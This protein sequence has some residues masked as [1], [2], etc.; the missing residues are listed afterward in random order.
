[1]DDVQLV[2]MLE[3]YPHVMTPKLQELISAKE[4]FSQL[5]SKVGE[6]L[7]EKRGAFFLHQK[8]THR[9]LRT[10]DDLLV[11]SET[12]TGKSCEII[13]F[14]EWA[15]EEMI[16]SRD[17]LSQNVDEKLAH[18]KRCYILARG[19]TQKNEIRNQLA[20]RC[21]RPGKYDTKAVNEANQERTQK[22][23]LT[24]ELKKFYT[25]TTYKTFA[26]KI[27][28]EFP[29]EED[30]E[31]LADAY[32]DCI[33]WVDEAHNLLIDPAVKTTVKEKDQI[34]RTMHRLFHL[35]RR[36][37]R[38][39]ST[40]TPMINGEEEIGSLMN[41]ILP[42]DG[43]I[44]QGFDYIN[45]SDNDLRVFFPD[46]P[47]D[48]RSGVN[49][50]TNAIITKEDIAQ[51]F[52][53]QF[54]PQPYYNFQNAELEDLE[55]YFR[56]RI[57]YVRASNPKVDVKYQGSQLDN[58]III[59]NITYQSLSVL[60]PT[61]M[62]LHQNSG[63]MRAI[64]SGKTDI[65]AEERQASN[66]VFPDG[67][68]GQGISEEEKQILRERKRIKR[69]AKEANGEIT[70]Q[71]ARRKRPEQTSI[72][73]IPLSIGQTEARAFRKYVVVDKDDYYATE[74]L[75]EWLNNLKSIAELSCKYAEIVRLVIEKPGNAFVYGEY[76]TG[77]GT[78]VLA[79]CFEGMG[80]TRYNESSSMFMGV[81]AGKIKPYCAGSDPDIITRKIRPEIKSYQEDANGR[82]IVPRRYALLTKETAK[83]ENKFHSM[84]EA[85]NSYENRHGDYIKVLISSRV[86]RDGINVN[87]VRQIHL[88]GSEWNQSGMYQALSRGIRATSH[89]DLL[90]EERSKRYKAITKIDEQILSLENMRDDGK[91]EPDAFD[92]ALNNLTEQRREIGDPDN[93]KIIVE[94]YK[95]AA[96]SLNPRKVFILTSILQIRDELNE[97]TKELLEQL[98]SE[99]IMPEPNTDLINE[100]EELLEQS[101]DINLLNDL[102]YYIEQYDNV[103]TEDPVLLKYDTVSK[104]R[105]LE[106]YVTAEGKDRRIKRILRFMKQCSVSCQ[107]H[108]DRNVTSTLGSYEDGSPECDYQACFYKCVDD[109][110]DFKDFS[111]HDILYAG[112][113]VDDAIDV[114]VNNFRFKNALSLKEI[115]SLMPQFRK[116]YV[117]MALEKIITSKIPLVDRFGYKT[118]LREDRGSFYLDRNF[119]AG[120]NPSYLMSLYTDGI[121][122][123]QQKSLTAIKADLEIET[124]QETLEK[125]ETLNPGDPQI[126]SL[127]NKLS[128]DGQANILETSLERYI[129]NDSTPIIDA[130]VAKYTDV[131]FPMKEPTSEL[132]KL[133]RGKPQTTRG[134]KRRPDAKRTV[135][136]LKTADLDRLRKVKEESQGEQVY[137]HTLYSQETNETSYAITAR[138][139]KAEGRLRLLKPSENTGW[140]DLNENETAVYNNFIQL[141]I[142][143]RTEK[144]EEY[145]IYGQILRDD[146]FRIIDK[147]AEGKTAKVDGRIRRRGIVCTT[148]KRARLIDI[149]WQIGVSEP[150]GDF[151][152]FTD[153]DRDDL[154]R[155]IVSKDKK[156]ADIVDEM[157]NWSL[158]QLIYYYKWH[159]SSKRNRVLMCD[160]IKRKMEDD[161]RII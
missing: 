23:N 121:V 44:P 119:P 27:F 160:E 18:F 37:K 101:D 122:A 50:K 89:E 127:L 32:S 56:G 70:V 77:S 12:G 52:R 131:I 69:L 35:S 96:L 152:T 53:G 95:H 142:Q 161:G 51:Y 88:I 157:V 145:G 139:N 21:S 120:T 58:E 148:I 136:T 47:F 25:V 1:M 43:I 85:M 6:R 9:Y 39:I 61:E 13:G 33:F 40:A 114:M 128:I 79:L 129:F 42:L 134:R 60:Y 133:A 106:M 143:E 49:P 116:K 125:L 72:S 24:N 138:Y 112:D 68:W 135:K 41:L 137:L 45:M 17:G 140:R 117:I 8:F 146:N 102:D 34:Y 118:Y 65:Y 110:P 75:Q 149:M 66:F 126:D 10:Y 19:P 86:G 98:E 36:C 16:K 103:D 100:L 159:K 29:K 73:N 94:I 84:M 132:R 4:E 93:V 55:P 141:E 22:T 113:I 48:P 31:K 87:N 150:I 11:I 57:T 144:Y 97:E 2:D 111:T 153:D 147:L 5:S 80:Y 20:C 71:R 59:E 74:E 26:K 123:L 99:K 104:S 109:L 83:A 154:I 3:S 91:I 105:D 82:I 90:S 78:I 54:P 63:Y 124:T 15:Y 156:K 30:N 67:Y 62:S 7:K 14:S 76:V 130:I 92:D 115:L 46:I 108:Y 155:F 151:S 28:R 38:I 158:N 81:G 107:I 64:Q